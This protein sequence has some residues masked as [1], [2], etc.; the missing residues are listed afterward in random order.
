[1]NLAAKEVSEESDYSSNLKITNLLNGELLKSPEHNKKLMAKLSQFQKILLITN[2]SVTELLEHYADEP[3]MLK[4]LY[5]EVVTDFN[6][7][8]NAHRAFI[9]ED[10]STILVRKGILQG[11]LTL[12]HYLYVESSILLDNLPNDFRD[13]LLK[14]QLPIGK[15]WAKYRSETY[16]TDFSMKQE[17]ADEYVAKNLNIKINSDVLSRTYSIYSREK[18]TMVITEK[19]SAESFVD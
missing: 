3:I 17:K 9:E 19:F 14:S 1:M 12:N 16:K 18:K 13:D 11:K 8:L 7:L 6:N 2:G 15:L 5:E 10:S 4:K